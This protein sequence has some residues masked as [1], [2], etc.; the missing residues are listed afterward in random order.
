ML[1]LSG[2][3]LLNILLTVYFAFSAKISSSS[4]WGSFGCVLGIRNYASKFL[5]FHIL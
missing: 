1:V 3:R 5:N 2:C 4:I